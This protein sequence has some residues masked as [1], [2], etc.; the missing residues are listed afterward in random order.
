MLARVAPQT[1][2]DNLHDLLD[3]SIP[4]RG[5]TVVCARAMQLS[6]QLGHHLFDTLYHA[7][8]LETEGALLVTAD[9]SYRVKAQQGGLGRIVALS[10]WLTQA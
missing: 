1:M 2:I 9:D 5:D 3:L 10:E 7:V 6:Q 4:T 8:A